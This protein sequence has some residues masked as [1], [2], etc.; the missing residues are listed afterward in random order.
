MGDVAVVNYGCA[1]HRVGSASLVDPLFMSSTAQTLIS[2]CNILISMLNGQLWVT[3]FSS[4]T[5]H[6]PL[7]NIL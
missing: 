3:F 1:D 4:V 2:I 5:K 6:S 7:F